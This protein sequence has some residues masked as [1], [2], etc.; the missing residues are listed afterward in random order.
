MHVLQSRAW[1]YTTST[2]DGNT[3]RC[4]TVRCNEMSWN[5]SDKVQSLFFFSV[6]I[7]ELFLATLLDA[8]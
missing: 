3:S 4:H 2:A 8:N 7:Q 6:L 5:E 1:E